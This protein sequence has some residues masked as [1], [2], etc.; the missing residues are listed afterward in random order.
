MRTLS[1]MH[2]NIRTDNLRA[3]LNDCFAMLLSVKTL[4]AGQSEPCTVQIIVTQRSQDIFGLGS[5]VS[6]LE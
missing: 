1:H 6:V 2:K 4:L 5:T 3:A